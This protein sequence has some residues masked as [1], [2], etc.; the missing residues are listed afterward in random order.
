MVEAARKHDQVVQVGTQRR[1]CPLWI[2]A[3]NK[4]KSG[5]LGEVLIR[6]WIV[7]RMGNIGH[8]EDGPTPPGVDYDL[9]LGPAPKRPF[10][11]NRFHYTWHWCWDKRLRHTPAGGRHLPVGRHIAENVEWLPIP[12]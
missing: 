12:T 8:K 7:H 10:N 5:V 9:W 3:M 6:T 11:P 2:D 1:S 4:I